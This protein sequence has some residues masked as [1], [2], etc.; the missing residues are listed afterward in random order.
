MQKEDVGMNHSRD[1]DA[2]R[3]AFGREGCPVCTVI[4][5]YLEHNMDSW[6]YEG[7]TD[8]EH[9]HQLIRS[10]GFCPLHTWQLAQRSNAFRLGLIYSEVLTDVLQNLDEDYS[11]LSSTESRN[12]KPGSAWNG[13]W[14]KRRHQTDVHPVF[15]Q[16]PFCS[17]RASAEERL[18]STLVQQLRSEEIRMLLSRS[19]GLCLAHFTQALQ[20][21]ELHDP[22]LLPHLLAC[23]RTCTRRVLEEVRELVRK[24][25]YRFSDESRGEEMTSWRRGA[26]LCAGNP[27]VF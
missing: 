23:Q 24:H 10:R 4:L 18:S 26:E 7:F 6:E 13:W 17:S 22:R 14:R 2:L 25:D 20:H 5:E 9:R 16:C 21:A 11:R 27:G 1:S 19:T 8:V 3:A 12:P 15:E